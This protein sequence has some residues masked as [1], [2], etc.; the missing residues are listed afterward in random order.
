[1][2]GAG[3]HG[4]VPSLRGV[5][6]EYSKKDGNI[7][8]HDE[9]RGNEE[10]HNACHHHSLLVGRGVLTG[11]FQDGHDFTEEMGNLS[12]TTDVEVQGVGGVQVM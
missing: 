6:A 3:G 7:R 11:Q 8:R 2:G 1:M 12:G 10:Q 4:F 9:G 5:H